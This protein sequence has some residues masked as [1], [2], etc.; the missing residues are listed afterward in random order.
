MTLLPTAGIAR[1]AEQ[2]LLYLMNPTTVVPQ[3]LRKVNTMK[4]VPMAR[5]SAMNDECYFCHGPDACYQRRDEH[6]HY[7]DACFACAKQHVVPKQFQ[8]K[9]LGCGKLIHIVGTNGGKMPCGGTLTVF[10]K[11]TIEYCETCR[12]ETPKL[13]A[14]WKLTPP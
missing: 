9:P 4:N 13:E 1:V 6:G 7:Q 5:T 12:P 10:G 8:K 11:K 14:Q 3:H 2:D